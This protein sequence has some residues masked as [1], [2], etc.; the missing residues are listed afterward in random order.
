MTI[1]ID[2]LPANLTTVCVSP[3][4]PLVSKED[5]STAACSPVSIANMARMN[6]EELND[7]KD[8]LALFSAIS[9]VG[10]LLSDFSSR[11]VW[12]RY[13]CNYKKSARY[14]YSIQTARS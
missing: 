14:Y 4:S 13:Q 3:N 10:T 7:P 11:F 6:R 1:N 2:K 9:R 5:K 8:V 12:I